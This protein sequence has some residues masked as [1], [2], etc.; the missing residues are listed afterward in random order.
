MEFYYF[1]NL[2]HKQQPYNSN[3][4]WAACLSGMIDGLNAQSKIGK[5]QRELASFYKEYTSNFYKVTYYNECCNGNNAPTGLC[6]KGI[7]DHHV[8]DI[9]EYS[10]F[11]A[12]VINQFDQL[13]YEAIK[14]IL[15]INQAPILIKFIK[16]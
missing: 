13:D 12:T 2:V 11:E 3:W 4:C 16:Y 14:N 9:Y 7:S 1:K 10:G 6:N 15:V 8:I 5:K